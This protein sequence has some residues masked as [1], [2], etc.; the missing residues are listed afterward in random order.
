MGGAPATPLPGSATIAVT[1]S[2]TLLRPTAATPQQQQPSATFSLTFDTSACSDARVRLAGVTAAIPWEASGEDVARHLN[3]LRNIGQGGVSAAA[4]G[5][6]PALGGSAVSRTWSIS[7]APSAFG[8][9]SACALPLLTVASASGNLTLPATAPIPAATL[10]TALT[11]S[12]GDWSAVLRRCDRVLLGNDLFS[13]HA[14]AAPFSPTSVPLAAPTVCTQGVQWRRGA[15][16]NLTA[17]YA[18]ATVALS[19]WDPPPSSMQRP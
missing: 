14:T 6:T 8:Y 12:G 13:V 10:T 15:A 5:E 9:T 2:F 19:P 16:V 7:F 17:L 1:Q 4:T 18:P 3:A 11:V